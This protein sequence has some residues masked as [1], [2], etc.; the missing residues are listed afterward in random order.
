M[1]LF[2]RQ[3]IVVLHQHAGMIQLRRSRENSDLSIPER[4]A[5]VKQVFCLSLL[6]RSLIAE[7]SAQPTAHSAE[8]KENI[9]NTFE[10]NN[11]ELAGQGMPIDI[12]PHFSLLPK[13]GQVGYSIEEAVA[14]LVDNSI[15]ARQGDT[16]DVAIMLGGIGDDKASQFLDVEDNGTG[17]TPEQAKNAVILG[18]SNKKAEDIGEFGMGMKTACTFIG[19]RFVVET[20]TEDDED[21]TLIV[22]DEEEFKT[23]AEVGADCL[24]QAQT[25]LTRHSHP[26]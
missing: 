11:P 24:S 23:A 26:Y 14:E 21:A 12:T 15:D 18:L 8:K 16:V 4:R 5:F 20:A 3:L 13:T 1:N 22:Y 19:G 7:L 17:M 9:M 2:S 6:R 10:M 25:L